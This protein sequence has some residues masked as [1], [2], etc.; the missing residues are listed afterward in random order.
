MITTQEKKQI[1]LAYLEAV[2]KKDLERISQ[3]VTTDCVVHYDDLTRSHADVIREH[4]GNLQDERHVIE[5]AVAEGDK[6][7][8]RMTSYYA[9]SKE[10]KWKHHYMAILRFR[11]GRIAESWHC[12]RNKIQVQE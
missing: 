9:P 10:P 1:F 4:V 3:L 7:A 12:L 11:D 2:R 8:V 5:D 6:L